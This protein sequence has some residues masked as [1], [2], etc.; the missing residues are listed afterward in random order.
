MNTNNPDRSTA[1]IFSRFFF[2][3]AILFLIPIFFTPI[4]QIN[5]T[6]PQYPEGLTM[7]IHYNNVTGAGD[8][9]LENI[10]L[11]NHYI[12][13]K[14]I[15]PDS[16]PELIYM[17]YIIGALVILG[18]LIVFIRKRGL[19]LTWVVI[20]IVVGSAG[21]Y[22]LNRWEY[23][24]GHDLNPM[25]PI[26]VEGMTYKP[27][28]LGNKQLL[29]I[30]AS[31]YPHIGGICFAFSIFIGMMATYMAY[32]RPI[33]EEDDDEGND[34][35][36]QNPSDN[37]KSSLSGYAANTIASMMI[38]FGGCSSGPSSINYG[39]DMCVNCSMIISDNKFGSEIY[40]KKGKTYKF[41]SG[42][43]MISFI[44][45]EAIDTAK[46]ESYLITDFS[47]PG[48]LV[49]ASKAFFIVSNA[50]NSPMGANLA[51]YSQ[52]AQRKSFFDR[53]GGDLYN[54]PTVRNNIRF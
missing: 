19:M 7:Y 34:S 16:I 13:M 44:N 38:L 6:A 4:W 27:P 31:S 53:H 18:L 11:L 5:L 25:A 52:E 1:N 46:I 3:G 9:D 49:D 32:Q 15:E 48:H 14:K 17:K 12:G 45:K 8:N 50:I 29:N 40:T 39:K 35:E 28:L 54:W 24:Y 30:T 20:S 2:F 21:I 51:A 41:D 22:D 10:N 36:K 23:D 33:H 47:N 37:K 42:E 43:C 26:K